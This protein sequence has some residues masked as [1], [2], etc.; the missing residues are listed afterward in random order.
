LLL[1]TPAARSFRTQNA[2][3]RQPLAWQRASP[4]FC[5]E[6]LQ[7]SVIKHRVGQ[8]LLQLGVLALQPPQALRLGDL[9]PTV[10]GLPVVERLLAQPMLAVQIGRLPGGPLLLQDRNDLLFRMPLALHRRLVPSRWARLQFALDQ[11][12]GATSLIIQT[13]PI[14]LDRRAQLGALTL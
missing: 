10:L 5:K 8:E 4:F 13:D 6:I 3:E 2:G 1:C 7:R 9:Q 14:T 12:K 11:F